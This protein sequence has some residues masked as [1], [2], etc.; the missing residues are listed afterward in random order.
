MHSMRR[1]SSEREDGWSCCMAKHRAIMTQSSSR[2]RLQTS[3][4][5]SLPVLLTGFMIAGLLWMSACSSEE[6]G[7]RFTD[8][9]R[10][11]PAFDSDSAYRHIETQVG[12]GPRV[13]N[14]QAHPGHS[15][16]SYSFQ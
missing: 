3:L 9:G 4:P 15:V 12:F 10:E 1:I 7:F 8:Q 16:L 14:T 5:L 6:E 13:P 2:F 11:V